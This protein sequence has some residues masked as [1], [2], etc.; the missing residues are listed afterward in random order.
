MSCASSHLHIPGGCAGVFLW[1]YKRK[2]SKHHSETS[3]PSPEGRFSRWHTGLVARRWHGAVLTRSRSARQRAASAGDAPSWPTRHVR[4]MERLCRMLSIGFK[5]RLLC[6][7]D[8]VS[9]RAVLQFQLQ[10]PSQRS[11]SSLFG[12]LSSPITALSLISKG[13][14]SVSHLLRTQ[15]K[16]RR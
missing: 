6:T 14:G 10:I 16:L 15:R 1:P 3:F 7:N 13:S 2:N 11:T 12:S 9:A 5:A 8:H 4:R